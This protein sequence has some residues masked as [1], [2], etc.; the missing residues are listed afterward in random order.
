MEDSSTPVKLFVGIMSAC[1]NRLS[2]ERRKSIRDTWKSFAL[3]RFPNVEIKFFLAQPENGAYDSVIFNTLFAFGFKWILI[4][5]HPIYCPW[6][7]V[8]FGPKKL[9]LLTNLMG[10]D[11]NESNLCL[12][13]FINFPVISQQFRMNHPIL[14]FL[15]PAWQIL[16]LEPNTCFPGSTCGTC[17][18]DSVIWLKQ[19][20]CPM[21]LACWRMRQPN[22]MTLWFSLDLM[23]TI[24]FQRRPL[25][26]SGTN[27]EL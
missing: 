7:R 4:F 20:R 17:I 13:S 23:C 18:T 3:E 22:L 24:T 25:V 19:R 14:S 6:G 8:L 9:G 12:I 11:S 15:L 10:H 26:F 2:Q 16:Q 1:C 27:S 21:Q 5:Y